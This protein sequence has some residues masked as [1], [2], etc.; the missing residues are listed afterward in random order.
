MVASDQ[1][2]PFIGVFRFFLFGGVYL[3][4]LMEFRKYFLKSPPI[5]LTRSIA[6]V[7]L[8]VCLLAGS[9]CRKRAELDYQNEQL[10]LTLNEHRATVAKLEAELTALGN[11]GQYTLTRKAHIQEL[12][13]RIESIKADN[14]RLSAER[15]AVKQ[16]VD[17]LQRELDEYKAKFANQ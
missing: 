3:P 6:V 2:D 8:S 4:S 16:S 9:G 10:Q 7:G 14:T 17:K 13:S 1:R 12:K 11:L 15:D 5:M